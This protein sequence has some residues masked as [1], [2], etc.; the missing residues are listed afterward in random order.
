MWATWRAGRGERLRACATCV[1]W[2][3][4][5]TWATWQAGRAERPQRARR[6]KQDVASVRDV[7][8]VCNVGNVGNVVACDVSNVATWARGCL[9]QGRRR[10][11]RST[12]TSERL[13]N[14]RMLETLKR[15][16]IYLYS[17][18]SSAP[19]SFRITGNV[20]RSLGVTLE[21]TVKVMVVILTASAPRT[22]WHPS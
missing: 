14:A 17:S 22:R 16:V 15:K 13:K 6:G 12:C 8:D 21:V 1:K 3:A 18:S 11:L 5:A 4:S 2:R 19:A 9:L 7:R 20:W 10:L